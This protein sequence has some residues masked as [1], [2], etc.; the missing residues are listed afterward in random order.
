ADR[1]GHDG[2]GVRAEEDLLV[3]PQES[4]GRPPG[5]GQARRADRPGELLDPP[6]LGGDVV[7]E[8]VAGEVV[9]VQGHEPAEALLARRVAA[10]EVAA[11]PPVDLEERVFAPE[12]RL[13]RRR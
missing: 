10:V 2:P 5:D 1:V 6:D 7:A 12:Q 9:A 11:G 8:G 3:L 13:D 4:A